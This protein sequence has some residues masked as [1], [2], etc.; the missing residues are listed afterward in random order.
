MG[1][2]L[3]IE[4]L[5]KQAS[6]I[7]GAVIL[8]SILFGIILSYYFDSITLPRKFW[9]I[10]ILYISGLVLIDKDLLNIKL[11]T[12]G[13]ILAL[14]AGLCWAIA[15]RGFKSGISLSNPT[16]YALFQ[17][18]TVLIIS[19]ILLFRTS[20]KEQSIS[21]NFL[22]KSKNVLLLAVLTVGG[23]MGS[24]FALYNSNIIYFTLI[25]AV[26]PATTVF[27]SKYIQKEKIS[28]QQILGAMVL[29]IGAMMV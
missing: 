28:N 11:P 14:G 25:S 29:I 2:L 19:A 23:I 22:V 7:S 16:T 27:I 3:F 10:S 13:T 26:Q 15:N 24:N 5:K 20:R 21:N 17:E 6:G 18:I 1:L 12:Q 4:S 8:W 9:T